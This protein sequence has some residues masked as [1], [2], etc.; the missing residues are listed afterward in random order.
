MEVTMVKLINF[1]NYDNLL[2]EL[3]P[4]INIFVGN[5]AQGKTNLLESVFVSACGKSFRTSKDSNLINI[6]KDQSYIGV[7]ISRKYSDRK[8]EIK[9]DR[10]KLKRI[11]IN[12]YEVEKTSDLFSCLNTVIFSPEDLK[13]IKEGPQI[14]R[15]FL[16]DEISRIKPVYRHDLHKYNKILYQRNNLIKSIRMKKVNADTLEVW[17]NQLVEIGTKL[18]MTR[19]IFINKLSKISSKIHA[20]IT[21]GNEELI[22][23]YNSSVDNNLANID[24]FNNELQADIAEKFK[25]KLKNNVT[26][27]IEKG[28]TSV[29]PHRDDLNVFIN[30]VNIRQYGSQGQQRTAALSLKL[31][32]VEL[33]KNEI[34]EYP[35]LLLDDV[36]SELDINRRTLLISSFKNIQTIITTTDEVNF[37]EFDKLEKSI[38]NINNGCIEHYSK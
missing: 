5:N 4:K 20:D 11:K 17:D 19:L 29:G 12:G 35:V 10:N 7:K 18:I 23:S 33:I 28:N 31:A 24:I 16:D 27:D 30:N 9:L 21:G 22:L 38:F 2:V 1:R 8:I 3:N 6:N 37:D 15:A 25:E 34:G 13:L 14:R 36:L 26:R 32:E